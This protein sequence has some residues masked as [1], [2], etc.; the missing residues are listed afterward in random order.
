MS[1]SHTPGPW[2]V[3][4]DHP[5]ADTAKSLAFVR[6]V[7]V[8]HLGHHGPSDIAQVY[9][10]GELDPEREANAILM[11]AAPDLLACLENAAMNATGERRARYL[12][13]IAKAKGEQP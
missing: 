5:D 9:C 13:A 4:H 6:Q 11:A 12:A 8:A 1:A 7:A 10:A 2:A 3:Y